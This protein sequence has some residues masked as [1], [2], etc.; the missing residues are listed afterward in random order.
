MKKHINKDNLVDDIVLTIAIIIAI[1][2]STT[3]MYGLQ[4]M[5]GGFRLYW[6]FIVFFILIK[7]VYNVVMHFIRKR[8]KK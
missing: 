3:L 4:M 7:L 5:I 6:F 1:I 8:N 2:I